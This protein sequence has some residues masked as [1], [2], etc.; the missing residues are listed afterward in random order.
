MSQFI[1]EDGSFGLSTEPSRLEHYKCFHDPSSADWITGEELLQLEETPDWN[2]VKTEI[3][4]FFY[5]PY[6]YG[7]NIGPIQKEQ[8]ESL[9]PQIE[10]L[11]QDLFLNK[12]LFFLLIISIVASSYFLY[13]SDALE[14]LVIPFIFVFYLLMKSS[15]L[16]ASL[17]AKELNFSIYSRELNFL[18]DQKKAIEDSRL[19]PTEIEDYFWKKVCDF[20]EKYIHKTFLKSIET[21]RNDA[22]KF[23][24]NTSLKDYGDYQ[25]PIF[26]VIP[27]WGFLQS[28]VR[29]S[30]MGGTQATGL[31][32]IANKLIERE[33][34]ATW[35]KGY[36]GRPIFRV[37][38]IQFLIFQENN[39]ELVSYYYD[40]ITNKSYSETIEAYQYSHITDYT[41]ADEDIS[42]MRKDPMI[43]GM[44]NIPDKLTSNI[45]GNQ[46]KTISLYS[47]SGSNYRCVIPDKDVTNGIDEWLKYNAD[48][49]VIKDELREALD[50]EAEEWWLDELLDSQQDYEGLIETLAWL[51]FKQIREKASEAKIPAHS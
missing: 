1:L 2:N 44:N 6:N 28:S 46:V 39:L 4:H 45:F 35:R 24:N 18:L 38:Y 42:Y 29:S 25:F 11:K 9:K 36:R 31:E 26:P 41:Y 43:V 30:S 20:E 19:R 3:W 14:F 32:I 48:Q 51:S 34:V 15:E 40:F 10:S 50:D 22:P 33:R 47:A 27:S 23:Y 37:W 5:R 17:A 21:V 16:K 13:K 12:F 49:R 7:N 8:L